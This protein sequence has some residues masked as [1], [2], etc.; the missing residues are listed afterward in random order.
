MLSDGRVLDPDPGN[1]DIPYRPEITPPAEV[2]DRLNRPFPYNT[3]TEKFA[4]MIQGVL[5]ARSG[6]DV[7]CPLLEPR[8]S[9]L[10]PRC[11]G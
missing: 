8:M 10:F 5:D 7:A 6:P 1:G 4:T 11:A 3:T 2:A 9:L